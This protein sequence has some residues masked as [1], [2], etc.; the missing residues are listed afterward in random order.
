ML[1]CNVKDVTCTVIIASDSI[2]MLS[3]LQVLN[4]MYIVGPYTYTLESYI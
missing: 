1:L 3:L 4:M 2:I